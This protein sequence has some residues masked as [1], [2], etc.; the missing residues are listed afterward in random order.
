[1]SGYQGFFAIMCFVFY[2]S[3]L[4][5]FKT[6]GLIVYV[7]DRE[8]IVMCRGVSHSFSVFFVK[9]K[10][11]FLSSFTNKRLSAS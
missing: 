9:T 7:A 1:M 3:P 10:R 2:V 6:E 4:P 5:F 11:S 8:N